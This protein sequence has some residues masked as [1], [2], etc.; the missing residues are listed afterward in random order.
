MKT[1]DVA[2]LVQDRDRWQA[3]ADQ[4]PALLWIT[5]ADGEVCG[6]NRSWL[7]WRGRRLDEERGGGWREAL[8]PEDA[9]FWESHFQLHLRQRRPFTTTVRLRSANGHFVTVTVSA[10]PWP[11]SDATFGGY[12]CAGQTESSEVTLTP[13]GDLYKAT[14]EALQEGVVVT[15]ERGLFIWVN[16]AAR[17]YLNLHGRDVLGRELTTETGDIDV[18]DEQGRPMPSAQRPTATSRRTRK[19]V[20]SSMLGWH[21]GDLGLRWF[22]V[23]SRTLLGEDG[24]VTAVVTSFLD[25]TAQ[26]HAADNARHEARHDALTG[27]VNRWGLPDV[28]REVLERTPRRG[29]DVA[30]AYCDLDN[31]KTVN[32]SLGHAAGDELLRLV[33]ARTR[34]RV[35]SSDVVAR[36]GGDEIVIVLDGV[37]GLAGAMAAAEKVRASIAR[38]GLIRGHLIT[39]HVSIGV[40]LLPSLDSLDETLARADEAMYEAK[41][42]GRNRVV[43][44]DR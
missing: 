22:T 14:I 44:L 15:D 37:D 33:A 21:V 7:S 3:M 42:A 9:P 8:H 10:R 34:D 16:E 41:A 23:N 40:A 38:P 30:L 28:V 19:P 2:A 24:Q 43:T 27:L 6:F 25:V 1:D 4:S 31:F 20:S 39:P 32:D 18:I 17:G 26:K 5:D 36:I 29:E 12:V 11:T 35:R 13:S